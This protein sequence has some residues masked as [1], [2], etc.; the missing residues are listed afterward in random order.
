MQ[1]CLRARKHTQVFSDEKLLALQVHHPY[2]GIAVRSL[3]SG[4]ARVATTFLRTKTMGMKTTRTGMDP[5]AMRRV[6]HSR[7]ALAGLVTLSWVRF[8]HPKVE[9]PHCPYQAHRRQC[10]NAERKYV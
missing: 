6:C 3:C 1:V 2:M 10:E 4:V 9:R 8:I 5:T 7:V